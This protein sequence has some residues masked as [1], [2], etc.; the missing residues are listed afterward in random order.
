[1]RFVDDPRERIR[2]WDTVCEQSK[3]LGE[4]FMED[5]DSMRIKELVEPMKIA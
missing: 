1:V 4:Q 2:R 3:I 5:V